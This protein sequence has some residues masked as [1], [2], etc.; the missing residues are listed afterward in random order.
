[1]E[2]IFKTIEGYENLYEI[3]NLGRVKNLKRGSILKNT[4]S[5]SRGYYT[6][7]IRKNG[8]QNTKQIHVLIAQAFIPNP[9]NKPIVD[10]IDQDRTNNKIDNLRYVTRSENG[11]NSDLQSNNKTGCI[12]VSFHKD[13]KTW[14][15][16]LNKDGKSYS[17]TFKNKEEAIKYRTE[18][19]QIHFGVYSPN[20]KPPTIIINITINN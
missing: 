6:V 19:E 11:M 1:M 3:S 18:L 14:C 9:D 4:L 13:N 17:K 15:A 20:Y 7:G 12:G 5:K 16:Q 2:E 8:N 10:H